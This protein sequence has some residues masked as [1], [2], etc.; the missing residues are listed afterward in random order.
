MDALEFL[1]TLV[2][3]PLC[4][5]IKSPDLD[6]YDF[7]FGNFVRVHNWHGEERIVCTHI[8]HVI[9]RL[10]VIWKNGGHRVDK[11]Y[12]DT[13]GEK[14]N[15]E[16]KRFIGLKVRQ[17]ELSDKNDLWLDLGDYW[18]VFATFENGEESW[19][20]FTSDIDSPHLVASD[21]WLHFSI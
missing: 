17:V 8:L 21:S 6:L 10:K 1:Q 16:V 3:Q 19:R 2:G 9:C 11:Y 4:Y 5:G 7:G 12:E 18:I 14:F 15:A 20:F 13:P